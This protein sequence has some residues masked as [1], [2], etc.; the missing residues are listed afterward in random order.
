MSTEKKESLLS[1]I[2]EKGM[3]AIKRPFIVKKE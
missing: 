3:D 2:I 1:Q